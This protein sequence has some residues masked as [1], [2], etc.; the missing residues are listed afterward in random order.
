[1][2]SIRRPKASGASRRHHDRRFRAHE[3]HGGVHAKCGPGLHEQALG[4]GE[5]LHLGHAIGKPIAL[6][7]IR[8]SEQELDGRHV[9][10]PTDQVLDR[11]RNVEVLDQRHVVGL[12]HPARRVRLGLPHSMAKGAGGRLSSR[13]PSPGS[14]H[15]RPANPAG[16]ACLAK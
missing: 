13:G 11:T 8:W 15:R 5:R 7:S 16:S 2:M 6:C 10:F 3:P 4:V 12:N 14:G 1:M 9:R